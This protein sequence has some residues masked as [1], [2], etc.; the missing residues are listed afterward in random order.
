MEVT[1]NIAGVSKAA[2]SSNASASQ[3]LSSADRLAQ[4]S[5]RLRGEVDRFLATVRAA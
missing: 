1:R 4:Q 5:E 2:E 3:V